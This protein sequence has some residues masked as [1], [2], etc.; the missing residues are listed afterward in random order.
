M[1]EKTVALP[2]EDPVT[3]G[4]NAARAI[5]DA[6]SEEERGRIEMGYH[7]YGIGFRFRQSMSTYFHHHLRLSRNCRRI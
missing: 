4:V 7:L 2:Y 1:V 5:I 3:F 6:L